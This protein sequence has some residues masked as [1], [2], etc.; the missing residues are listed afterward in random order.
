MWEVKN[1]NLIAKVG[2][3]GVGARTSVF[4]KPLGTEQ[5]SLELV[6]L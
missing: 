2:D 3:F 1:G 5:V 6:S 4:V